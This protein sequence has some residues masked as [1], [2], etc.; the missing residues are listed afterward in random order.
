MPVN[1]LNA[2]ASKSGKTKKE[3]E[4]YWKE[5]KKAAKKKGLDDKDDAFWAYVLGTVKRMVGMTNESIDECTAVLFTDPVLRLHKLVEFMGDR[6]KALLL[7]EQCKVQS[8]TWQ[9]NNST[10]KNETI[11]Y[12]F[13]IFETASFYS[14]RLGEGFFGSSPD[15][16]RKSI[17]KRIKNLLDKVELKKLIDDGYD[18]NSISDEGLVSLEK[19]LV[20]L[21]KDKNSS[22]FAGL[23]GTMVLG[24]MGGIAAAKAI[25]SFFSM[26]RE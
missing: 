4:G 2:L 15:K 26:F 5:A 20:K 9:E 19:Q 22:G 14:S 11:E 1:A 13:E 16:K 3:L 25:D 18:I 7:W 21:K 10:S 6:Q 23:L 12:A 17:D 24:F 8:L